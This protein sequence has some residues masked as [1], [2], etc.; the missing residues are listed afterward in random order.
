MRHIA[1]LFLA[2]LLVPAAAVLG[3][4]GTAPAVFSVLTPGESAR[5]AAVIDG[6]TV[7]LADGAEVRLVG[8]QAP[9]LPL[10]RPHVRQWPLADAAKAALEAMVAGREV[11]LAFGDRDEDRH[12]RR[13]AHLAVDGMWVQGEMLRL[14]MARVYTFA[15]NRK[16]IAEMLALERQ[17]RA[18]GR[19]IW[20]DPFYRVLEADELDDERDA[21]SFQLIE[22]RVV[23]AEK[24]GRYVYLNFGSDYR[25]DFTAVIVPE[26]RKLFGQGGPDPAAYAGRSVRVRGWIESFNGPM[27]EITHPEQIEVLE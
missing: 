1:L 23:Q 20:A 14:G 15:D 16:L 4:V 22:G 10:G 7:A 11:M 5:V 27:I 17:A 18:A 12:G 21:G 19:G 13:L 25:S 26:A 24:V 6:D 8:I 2:L 3:A 9:K